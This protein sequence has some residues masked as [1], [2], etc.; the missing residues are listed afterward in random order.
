[1][2]KYFKTLSYL[3]LISLLF[4][5]PVYLNASIPTT[6]TSTSN[7]EFKKL[8]TQ[9]ISDL[10]TIQNRIFRASQLTIEQPLKSSLLKS[11]LNSINSDITK[12]R[13]QVVDYDSTIP[14]NDL[15]SSI[16]LLL[17][18]AINDTQNS[19]YQL[20]SL[21]SASNSLDKIL[22][23]EDYF[24]FKKSGEQTLNEVEKRLSRY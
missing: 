24:Q 9:F 10:N 3:L 22:L 5:N 8:I 7:A 21:S 2:K 4:L 11:E 17:R 15:R 16:L 23:L 12:L 1:M 18:S 13:K 20:D 19:L 14:N 6:I